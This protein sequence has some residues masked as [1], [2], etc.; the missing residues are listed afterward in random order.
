MMKK[1]GFVD[2]WKTRVTT[3]SYTSIREG[4]IFGDVQPQ[5][6]I[7][8][9]NPISPYMYILYAEWLSSIFRRHEEMGLLHEC[10]IAKGHI[11]C[12]IYYLRMTPIF[13]LEL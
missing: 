1:F 2:I 12:H 7:R 3:V 9:G 10:S 4:E 6:R 13:S 11:L 5:R 8:Q